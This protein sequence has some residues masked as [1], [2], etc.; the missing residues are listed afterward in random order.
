MKKSIDIDEIIWT[1]ANIEADRRSISID[2][3]SKTSIGSIPWHGYQKD[4]SEE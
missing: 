1:K 2:D 3:S 4:M